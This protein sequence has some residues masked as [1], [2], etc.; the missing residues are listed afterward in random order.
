MNSVNSKQGGEDGTTTP[1][2]VAVVGAAPPP[3]VAQNA[4]LGAGGKQL[5]KA[6]TRDCLETANIPGK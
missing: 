5:R 4:V 6:S 1:A 2:Q 3:P